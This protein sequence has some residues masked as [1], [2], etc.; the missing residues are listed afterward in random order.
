MR[1]KRQRR[2]REKRKRWQRE[3][4]KLQEKFTV[5]H[6]MESVRRRNQGRDVSNIL[7]ED[8]GELN[9]LKQF[10]NLAS[11]RVQGQRS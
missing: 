4:R 6:P 9:P 5:D 8:P 11:E 1:E 2:R 3:K 7:A 10:S